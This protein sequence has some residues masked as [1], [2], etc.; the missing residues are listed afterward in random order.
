MIKF[1]YLCITLI[2]VTV[3]ALAGNAS[4]DAPASQKEKWRTDDT[5]HPQAF[6]RFGASHIVV[7]LRAHASQHVE[8]V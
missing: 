2:L 8:P 1:K 3:V 7:S 5:L 6:E 4:V